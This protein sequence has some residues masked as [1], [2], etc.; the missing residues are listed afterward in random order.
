MSTVLAFVFDCRHLPRFI[1]PHQRQLLAFDL[2]AIIFFRPPLRRRQLPLSPTSASYANLVS[3][4]T[5][6]GGRLLPTPRTTRTS[7]DGPR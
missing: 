4:V 2:A 1:F 3:P 6:T 5:G 7:A